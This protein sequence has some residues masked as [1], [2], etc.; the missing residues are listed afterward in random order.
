[1]VIVHPELLH[2]YG[3]GYDFWL[4]D[5]CDSDDIGRWVMESWDSAEHAT[6]AEEI[7]QWV[8]FAHACENEL[9]ARY[10]EQLEPEYDY[11]EVTVERY[12]SLDMLRDAAEWARRDMRDF[13][14][15]CGVVAN[16]IAA[17]TDLMDLI[18]CNHMY[19]VGLGD[20]AE[21]YEKLWSK[22]ELLKKAMTPEWKV[23]AQRQAELYS[24]VHYD[25][26]EWSG[27]YSPNEDI[28]F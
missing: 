14:R 3:P 16:C 5:G 9:D 7:E 15:S 25:Y 24:A 6:T 19:E 10:Y 26:W 28:P 13:G 11:R 23:V 21:M 20:D 12:T 22:R 27:G 4:F 2:S 17:L 1:M 8:M 18:K